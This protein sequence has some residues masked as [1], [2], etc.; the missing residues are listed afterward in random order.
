MFESSAVPY[1]AW[2]AARFFTTSAD[3]PGASD[4]G[5]SRNWRS[6]GNPAGKVISNVFT[7]RAADVPELDPLEVVVRHSGN[8]RR[9]RTASPLPGGS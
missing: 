6:N 3:S 8:G 5:S 9:F 1:R 2:K 7:V 4:F